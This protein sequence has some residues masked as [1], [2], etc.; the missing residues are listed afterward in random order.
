MR[1]RRHVFTADI[2]AGMSVPC[3]SEIEARKK[4]GS[5]TAWSP[6]KALNVAVEHLA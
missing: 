6:S 2:A 4:P 5:L 3:L 1:V